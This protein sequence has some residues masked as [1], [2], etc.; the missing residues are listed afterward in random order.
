[1][2][3]RRKFRPVEGQGG[4]VRRKFTG[5]V[6]QL[7]GL[8]PHCRGS[9]TRSVYHRHWQPLQRVEP[10]CCFAANSQHSFQPLV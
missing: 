10:K 2:I 8:D 5:R 6:H 4:L 3:W 7:L 1:M 9:L